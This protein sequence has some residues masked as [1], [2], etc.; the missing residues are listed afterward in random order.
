VSNGFRRPIASEIDPNQQLAER[1]TGQGG[2]DGQLDR[3]RLGAQVRRDLRKGSQ[4]EID[5]Q[6][7]DGGQ[8]AQ[9]QDEAGAD[10]GQPGRQPED[11]GCRRGLRGG[12]RDHVKCLSRV[13]DGWAARVSSAIGE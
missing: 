3:R 9:Q 12:R 10:P 13:V 8:R 7:T 6:R 11:C 2:G 5:G 1:E 4:I